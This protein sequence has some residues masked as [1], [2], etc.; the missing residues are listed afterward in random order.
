MNTLFN[1]WPFSRLPNSIKPRFDGSGNLMQF[2]AVC[3]LW[4]AVFFLLAASASHWTNVQLPLVWEWVSIILTFVGTLW[5]GSGVIYEKP[6]NMPFQNLTDLSEHV[7][8]TFAY[9]SRTCLFG[10][11]IVVAGFVALLISKLAGH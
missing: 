9:A 10:V 4:D 6:G 11:S 7:T 2:L 3:V 1:L 8:A 5:I